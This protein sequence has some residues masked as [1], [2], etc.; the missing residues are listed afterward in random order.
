MAKSPVAGRVKT[1]LCPPLTP[2]QAALVARAALVD[3][4]AAVAESE[5]DRR[6]LALDGEPGEWLPAGF[7]VLPQRGHTFAERLA[8]AWIDCG[9]PTLQIG[10]DTPQVTA[11][12]LNAAMAMLRTAPSGAVLGLADDGGWWALGMTA[13]DRTV[14]DDVPMST[15]WTGAAQREALVRRGMLPVLLPSVRD[16]DGWADALHV[17]GL[18]PGGVFGSVVD[19]LLVGG[20]LPDEREAAS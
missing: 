4:L 11:A 3:T 20:V 16:V 7:E 18:H 13:V 2:E 15:V 10:M 6:V 9:A 5:A 14:F 1:R 19:G 12:E 8:H 17:A